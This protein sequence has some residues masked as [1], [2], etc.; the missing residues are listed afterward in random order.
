MDHLLRIRKLRPTPFKL[1]YKKKFHPVYQNTH[2]FHC[3]VKMMKGIQ[4]VDYKE[5]NIH[6]VLYKQAIKHVNH[7]VN[8]VD[9]G[10]RDGEFTRYLTWNFDHVYCFDYRKRIQFAMNIDLSK[11]QVTHY[12]CGLG[13]EAST[14]PA[15]GRGN[16]R[17]T[18]GNQDERYAR[19]TVNIYPLDYFQLQNINLIKVDVDG[20][21]EEVIKGALDTIKK[22]M[23]VII[24]EEIVADNGKPNHNGIN[25]LKSLDYDI[26]YLH[27][28][29]NSIHKDYVLTPKK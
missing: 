14:E 18:K 3:A 17:A 7:K 8:A 22:F 15:S 27:H 1:I 28:K 2:T 11:N 5:N 10:C 25:F 6:H 29:P 24:I 4:M 9:V 12:T 21:D 19:E 20:M 16:L 13:K 23:P 26:A